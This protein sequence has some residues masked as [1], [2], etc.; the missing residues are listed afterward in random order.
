MIS[1]AGL[2]IRTPKHE[3]VEA[4]SPS[5]SHEPCEQLR[6]ASKTRGI[7]ISISTLVDCQ[8]MRAE[9]SLQHSRSVDC[10][11]EAVA[12]LEPTAPVKNAVKSFPYGKKKEIR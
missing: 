4:T 6:T 9:A 2:E 3:I 8:F 5:I 1:L 7:A 12:R 10:R 11:L